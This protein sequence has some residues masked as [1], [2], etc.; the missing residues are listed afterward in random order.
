MWLLWYLYM[1]YVGTLIF[2]YAYVHANNI[3]TWHDYLQAGYFINLS[4][5]QDRLKI[6]QRSLE[7][8]RLKQIVVRLEAVAASPGF[9]GCTQSHL[10]A[11]RNFLQSSS[12]KEA[13]NPAK[14]WYIIFEDDFY[15]TKPTLQ[16]RRCIE[17]ALQTPACQVIM[18]SANVLREKRHIRPGLIETDGAYCG[19]SY[20]IR[21][22][23][24]ATLEYIYEQ[25]L[26]EKKPL[27]V[28]WLP[29]QSAGNRARSCVRLKLS[30]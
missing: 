14:L 4:H 22:S 29:W 1:M 15:V 6:I 18:L 7:I 13:K 3:P 2:M 16:K 10:N 17:H 8:L 27:D 26:V 11:I 25:A 30:L 28:M 5:R 12:Y 24:L 21:G 9:M 19:S 23:Y 20:M